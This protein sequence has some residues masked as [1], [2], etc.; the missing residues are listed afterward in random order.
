MALGW[1]LKRR[2]VTLKTVKYLLKLD[3]A[4][5]KFS[6]LVVNLRDTNLAIAREVLRAHAAQLN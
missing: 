5:S 6:Y 3:A 1:L 2:L 4:G